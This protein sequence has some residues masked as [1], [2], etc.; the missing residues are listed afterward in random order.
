[1]TDHGNTVE[2]IAPDRQRRQRTGLL[3]CLLV[4]WL[5]AGSAR[6]G[7]TGWRWSQAPEPAGAGL[8]FPDE[9]DYWTCA[10]NL[11]EGRG[12]ADVDGR[13][14]TRMPLYPWLLSL[15]VDMPDGTWWFRIAQGLLG[16]LVAPLIALLAWRLGGLRVAWLAGFAAAFDPYLVYFS[17]LLLTEALFTAALAAFFVVAWPLGIPDGRGRTW[18]W[19]PAGVIFAVMVYLRPSVVGLLPLWGLC[20]SVSARRAIGNFAGLV[21]MSLILAAALG[22]WAWRN[23]RVLGEPI[24]LTTRTGI[25]LYDGLGP[26]ADGSSNLAFTRDMAAHELG[27]AEWDRWFRNEALKTIWADPARVARLALIKAGRTWDPLPHAAEAQSTGVRIISGVWTIGVYALALA[28]LVIWRRHRGVLGYLLLPAI[29]LTLI[30]MVFVGS[31][32]YRLPAMPL[33]E[34][35]AAVGACGLIGIGRPAWRPRTPRTAPGTGDHAPTSWLERQ[36]APSRYGRKPVPSWRRRLAMATLLLLAASYYGYQHYTSDER[37]RQQAV[38]FLE[39]FTGGDV[40][41]DQASFDLFGGVSLHDVTISLPPDVKIDPTARTRRDR[42]VFAAVTLQLQHEPLGLFTGKLVVTS[43]LAD[44]PT[45][46]IVKNADHPKYTYNWEALFPPLPKK[47]KP[48]EPQMPEIH[49][50]N[51]RVRIVEVRDGERVVEPEIRLSAMALP[52]PHRR[53]TYVIPWRKAGERAEEGRLYYNRKAGAYTGELPTL[54]M[55]TILASMPE[56]YTDWL[57][58]LEIAGQIRPDNINF[59]RKRGSRATIHMEGIRLSVPTSSEQ[60]PTTQASKRFLQLTNVAGTLALTPDESK[61]SFTGLVNGTPCEVRAE[62]TGYA[63]PLE[64]AGFDIHI[65]A[66]GIVLPDPNDPA[67]LR[68]IRSIDKVNAFFEDFDPHGRADIDFT[69][70]KAPGKDMGVLLRG[71][72][73]PRGCDASYRRFPYR[74]R[75]ITGRARFTADGIFIE[76]ISGYHGSALVTIDGYLR[77]PELQTGFS[78]DIEADAVPL[79]SEIF[80]AIPERFR[81]VWRQFEPVGLAN[82]TAW[83]GRPHVDYDQEAL[84]IQTHIDADLLDVTACFEGFPYRLN[85][86]RGRMVV[87]NDRITVA[88]LTGMHHDASVRIDGVARYGGEPD[89]RNVEFRLEAA[90]L[91]LDDDLAQ[92]VPEA[93][94]DRL[95][96]LRPTGKVD[97][98]GRVFTTPAD[99]DIAYD[100]AAHLRD[101]GIRYRDL[102]YEVTD[103]TGVVALRPDDIELRK[104]RGRHGPTKIA[105]DGRFNHSGPVPQV[106]LGLDCRQLMLDDELFGTLPESLRERWETFAPKGVVDLRTDVRWSGEGEQRQTTHDTTID[107]R[108]INVCYESLPLPLSDVTG[109]VRLTDERVELKEL[110]GYHN[111]GRIRLDGEVALADPNRTALIQLRVENLPLT[112]EV[113][114]ALPDRLG[115]T[116]DALE[117]TGVLDLSLDELSYQQSPNQPARW[118][119]RGRLGLRDATLKLGFEATQLRGSLSGEGTAIADGSSMTVDGRLELDRVAVNKRVLSNVVGSMVR[120][121]GSNRLYL[122]D[123]QGKTYD[124]QAAGY[125]EIDFSRGRTKYALNMLVHDMSLGPFLNSTR[126]PDEPKTD[127]KGIVDGRLYL[128]GVAGDPN[129]LRGGGSVRLRKAEMYQ[130]PIVLA[131]LSALNITIPDVNAFNEADASY[132]LQGSRLMFDKIELWGRSLSMLG[133]G[134]MNLDSQEI[135]L[136]FITGSPHRLPKIPLLTE[137]A[138]GASRELMEIA[139]TGPLSSPRLEGRPLRSLRLTLQA[140]LGGGPPEPPPPPTP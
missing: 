27:E 93:S 91:A 43:L 75:N 41:I 125:A 115:S 8:V 51:A 62:V 4:V 89:Q 77:A 139:I 11:A 15:V 63:G 138:Q 40:R 32:R 109:Q 28:G 12:L 37:I 65:R 73:T 14:A 99:R 7:W 52:D 113:R 56:R 29:Y 104:L 119:Y 74:L 18:R 100:V 70:F 86:V 103:M 134:Y 105:I 114:A 50:R 117:P 69:L 2:G 20:V 48:G 3:L 85:H 25:S 6:V 16:A 87:E 35:I 22:P 135:D 54:P 31:I 98:V 46:T 90:G 121:A 84:P 58:T 49:I 10:T 71:T 1:M 66:K 36:L 33:I 131:M 23:D 26:R 42:R 5:L 120:E 96:E 68:F 53:E 116:W 78:L 67:G 13:R 19:L 102:P 110:S 88:R 95:D 21:L 59:D 83:V 97:L 128:A 17:G 82:L 39:R 80:A 34:L 140:L 122:R 112:E 45:V 38:T 60:R 94:R 127:A 107:A 72:M 123:L 79:D 76:N 47:D 81:T 136:L 108:G 137:I 101:V 132:T 24:L 111:G 106:R 55:T 129:A 130:L 57:E 92:A 44:E 30:H 133:S 118:G 124:G 64:E 126:E 9:L 61:A